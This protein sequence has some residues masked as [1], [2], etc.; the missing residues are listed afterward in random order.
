MTLIIVRQTH[1]H[2][3]RYLELTVMTFAAWKRDANND[4]EVPAT[5]FDHCP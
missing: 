1:Q 3:C 2:R 4:S 5:A